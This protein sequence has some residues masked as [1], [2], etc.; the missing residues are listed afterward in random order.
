MIDNRQ[1]SNH[2]RHGHFAQLSLKLIDERVKLTK[3]SVQETE[4]VIEES[5][6][7]LTGRFT[8]TTPA[9]PL[10]PQVKSS[11]VSGKQSAHF[12]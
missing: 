8:L 4:R 3:Q 10:S 1:P 2:G 9:P 12:A 11:R 5:R 7:L 6:A